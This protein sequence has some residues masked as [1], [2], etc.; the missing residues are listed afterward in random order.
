MAFQFQTVIHRL[1]WIGWDNWALATFGTLE[2]ADSYKRG[3][4]SH[5]RLIFQ[6]ASLEYGTRFSKHSPKTTSQ[7]C[8]LGIFELVGDNYSIPFIFK[9]REDSLKH[10][11][12]VV[13]R[14]HWFSLLQPFAP[15][16]PHPQHGNHL[17]T[18]WQSTHSHK[19][20]EEVL[21]GKEEDARS[22]KG[23]WQWSW[24]IPFSE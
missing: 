16:L 5:E 7:R 4:L 14:S 11:H 3:C 21:H 12:L 13:L 1:F 8:S 18:Q 9:R 2:P 17:L 20:V 23:S 24:K 6:C 22:T 15:K 19:K 10:W